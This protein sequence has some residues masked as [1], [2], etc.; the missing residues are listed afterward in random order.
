MDKYET[1]STLEAL[2]EEGF[3]SRT[4]ACKI[5]SEAYNEGKIER[6]QAED[7]FELVRKNS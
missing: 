7:L 3:M 6:H 5:V 1:Y 4:T 2:I